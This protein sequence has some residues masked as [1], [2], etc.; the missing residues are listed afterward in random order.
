MNKCESVLTGS[1]LPR[2]FGR[3]LFSLHI[4]ALHG[5][6]FLSSSLLQIYGKTT[7]TYQTTT[8][9][10]KKCVFG[11]YYKLPTQIIQIFFRFFILETD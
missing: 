1:L 6:L 5:I 4:K 10:P 9:V 3:L 2:L 7:L 8:P 11:N